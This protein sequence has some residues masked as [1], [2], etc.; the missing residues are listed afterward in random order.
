MKWA[1]SINLNLNL[2]M[3]PTIPLA[4]KLPA[5]SA[6]DSFRSVIFIIP[7]CW[8]EMLLRLVLFFI[9]TH[10]SCPVCAR[11]NSTGEGRDATSSS[12]RFEN[13]FIYS[14]PILNCTL[15]I[16]WVVAILDLCQCLPFSRAS[17][18]TQRYIFKCSVPK[19]GLQHSTWRRVLQIS[20]LQ[21]HRSFCVLAFEGTKY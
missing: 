17:D 5:D 18:L 20:I 3:L 13:Q 6:C 1:I 7:R 15:Y 2:K 10:C 19:V 12:S 9:P 21:L 16:W 14:K 4:P 11:H 8:A